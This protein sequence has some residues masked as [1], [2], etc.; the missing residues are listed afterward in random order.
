MNKYSLLF[1]KVNLFYKKANKSLY[2]LY[3]KANIDA[4]DSPPTEEEK[5]GYDQGALEAQDS[6]AEKSDAQTLRT[7]YNKLIQGITKTKN[8]YSKGYLKGYF[9]ELVSFVQKQ[10]AEHAK[11]I[12]DDF[13]RDS[14]ADQIDFAKE[15][16]ARPENFSG[17][18]KFYW[19]T[20]IKALQQY[21]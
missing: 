19:D 13:G 18:N 8:P 9:K 21:V 5:E 6:L 15:E 3:S 11:N 20:H 1:N 4:I 10:A 17:I 12:F 16:A 14:I 7:N 2:N